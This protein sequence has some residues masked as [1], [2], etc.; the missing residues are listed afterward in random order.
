MKYINA[1]LVDYSDY[2]PL[3]SSRNALARKR[4][5]EITQSLDKNGVYLMDIIRKEG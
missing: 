3:K 1:E 2:Y 4:Y 5:Q